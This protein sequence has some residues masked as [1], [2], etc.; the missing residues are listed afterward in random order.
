M[1]TP[2][3]RQIASWFSVACF[4]A[5]TLNLS[6]ATANFTGAVNSDYKNVGNWSGGA[7]P[8]TANGDTAVIANGS[9]V[10]YDP[11]LAPAGDYVISNGGTLQ[12]TN[13][14][15]SQI[16]SGAWIQL[17][18]GG[19]DGNGHILV[20]G[21]TFNQGT[22]GNTPFNVSG[23]GNTFTITSGSANFTSQVNAVSG[24][25]WNINGGTT[26]MTAGPLIVQSGGRVNVSAGTLNLG[27]N[28]VLENG[29]TWNQT[30]GTVNLGAN[31]EF[32]FNS[33]S[34]S[35]MS[36]GTLNIGKL[37]TG[38]NGPVGSTFNFSGGVINNGA[39]S[40]SGM[41]GGDNGDHPLNFT[42]GSTGVINFL[43]GNTNIA[44]VN[45]WLVAG[46]ILYNN[47]INPNAFQI[48][49]LGGPGTTVSLS[50]ISAI[51]EPSTY[52]F[53]GGLVA[54]AAAVYRRR[55]SAR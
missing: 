24:I 6:A 46:G 19:V 20:N 13:G 35:S 18:A 34:G 17:G 38:V 28:L 44:D 48:S 21:G 33:L 54:V 55:R 53:F 43:N 3:Q 47:A 32:N 29:S 40:F 4:S 8:D 50:L 1:H 52:A 2:T 49:Q 39:T 14:S 11:S 7:I 26:A 15:W 25:T 12:V 27:G 30:G 37:F 16:T 10:T 42:L 31:A 5:L 51:P 22:A 23:T 45:G 9:A 41:Y 36:G